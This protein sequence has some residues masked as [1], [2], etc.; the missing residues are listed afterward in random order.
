MSLVGTGLSLAVDLA[1]GLWLGSIVFFSFVAAPRTF[2]VLSRDRAGAVVGDIFPRYYRIGVALGT[3]AVVAAVAAAIRLALTRS[4][5]VVIV[6]TGVAVGLAAYS[7]WVLVP[8]MDAAGDDAFARY[9]RRS[10]LLNAMT[11]LFVGVAFVASH[12]TTWR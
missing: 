1:L 4:L 2:A 11:L 5:L 9:H 3:V 12:A 6:A 8:K 10:V 7:A